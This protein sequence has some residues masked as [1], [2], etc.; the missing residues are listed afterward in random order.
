MADDI[1]DTVT[2]KQELRTFNSMRAIPKRKKIWNM[3]TDFLEQALN[4]DM[5]HL[6]LYHIR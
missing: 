1:V 4:K 5:I 3:L 2:K 6:I